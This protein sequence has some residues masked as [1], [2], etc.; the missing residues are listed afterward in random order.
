MRSRRVV[1]VVMTAV[2]ALISIQPAT[3]ATSPF[4]LQTAGPRSVAAAEIRKALAGQ[5][6]SGPD[7][8][9]RYGGY[10]LGAVFDG[11]YACGPSTGMADP[12]DSVGFQCVELSTRFL[13][14]VYGRYVANVPDGKDFVSYANHQL[15]LPVGVPGPN[16][17]PAPGNIVSIAGG[18]TSPAYGHTAVVAATNVNRNG[19]GR[20]RVIEE[21]ASSSGWGEIIVRS[22]VESFGGP[23]Y[24]SQNAISWLQTSGQPVRLPLGQKI[25]FDVQPLGKN[26]VVTG[27]NKTGSATGLITSESGSHLLVQRPFVYSLGRLSVL[28]TPSNV[29]SLT[30]SAAINDPGQL[31]VSAEVGHAPTIA[32]AVGESN[33]HRWRRLPN[34]ISRAGSSAAL[35]I[36]DKGDIAGWAAGPGA[37]VQTVGVV[38]SRD[39][40]VYTPRIYQPSHGFTNA[41][42]Y[43]G[44]RIGDVVGTETSSSGEFY[45]TIWLHGGGVYRLPAMP[46][47]PPGTGSASAISMGKSVNP[48]F[49]TVIG[50]SDVGHS[51]V[52]STEWRIRV[53]G[54]RLK[55]LRVRHLGM[56]SQALQS[57]AVGVNSRG[58]VVGDSIAPRKEHGARL[59]FLVRPKIGMIPLSLIVA[60]GAHW[61]IAQAY[62][63]NAVGQVVAEGYQVR[64]SRQGPK[65][66]LLLT[67]VRKSK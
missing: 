17:V 14:V 40:R 4:H 16:S 9:A 23:G 48:R 2:W 42:L 29:G 61:N 8:C 46:G 12:F 66:G 37:R 30:E 57:V 38:W 64:G 6:G 24:G 39:G 50:S 55:V 65:E 5:E 3:A 44:D 7:W 47:R 56:I 60:G 15:H 25:R 22:W 13:W 21:N 59:A 53:S 28:P 31:A 35:G 45:P 27:I 54:Q 32:F 26:T 41:R 62:G 1:I 67:P 36:N 20:I 34:P 19:N 11:V 33:K 63:V 18:V 58:W 51:S 52:E 43:S 49:L 10:R